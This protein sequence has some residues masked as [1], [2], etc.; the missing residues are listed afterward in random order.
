MDQL[1]NEASG[2]LKLLFEDLSKATVGH[3]EEKLHNAGDNEDHVNMQ[4]AK[5]QNRLD[6]ILP[7]ASQDSA[8]YYKILTMKYSL[9]YEKAKIYLN[10]EEIDSAQ[11]VLEKLLSQIL[12]HKNHAQLTFLYL[13]TINHLAYLL[14]KKGEL[15]KAREL[16]EEVTKERL[17]DILVYR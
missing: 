12:E 10:R 13:R 6:A 9:E 17:E 11:S 3:A 7:N 15:E 5:L 1:S 14:S 4:F 2:E 8:L 16:L